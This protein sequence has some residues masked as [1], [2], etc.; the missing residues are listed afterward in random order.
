M[1]LRRR[2]LMQ[3]R[4]LAY[5]ASACQPYPELLSERPQGVAS[6]APRP[7]NPMPTSHLVTNGIKLFLQGTL[8]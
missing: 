1:G 8:Q 2:D 7:S 3:S 5:A 4:A 6:R